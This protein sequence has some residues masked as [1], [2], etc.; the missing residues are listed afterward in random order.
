MPLANTLQQP[1]E[2]VQD[3]LEHPRT[4]ELSQAQQDAYKKKI[5]ELLSITKTVI[6][7]HY[8]TDPVVQALAEETGGCVADALE[9]ARFGKK[10]PADNLMVAGV[11]FMG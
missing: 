7:A 3:Y 1:R 8:Y 4:A 9:M 2:F 11:K 5:K 10:H 6:I